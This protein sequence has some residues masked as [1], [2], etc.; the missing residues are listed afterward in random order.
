MAKKNKKSIGRGIAEKAGV[1]SKSPTPR[2]LIKTS[3]GDYHVGKEDMFVT[4]SKT[5]G[6]EKDSGGKHIFRL[7]DFHVVAY[8]TG[9]PRGFKSRSPLRKT[10]THVRRKK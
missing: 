2:R 6:F 4:G 9:P 8:E 1:V 5:G 10:R 3:T 7:P